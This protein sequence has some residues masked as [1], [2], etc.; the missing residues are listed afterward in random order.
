MFV[1]TLIIFSTIGFEYLSVDPVAHRVGM[2]YAMMNDGYSV[3]Y[4]P[5]G[6]AFSTTTYYSASYLNYMGGTNFG[7]L[8]YERS[9]LGI[10][11]RYFNSGTM[12]KT[13]EW[14]NEYGGFGAQFIDLNVGKGFIYKTVG[15]GFSAKIV[16]ENID[17]LYALG[18]GIDIG[19][20]HT[21]AQPGIQIGLALKNAGFGIKSFIN[22]NETLPYEIDLGVIKQFGPGW[23]GL[24]LAKPALT[25]FGLRV[26]GGY[27]VTPLVTLKASYNT[28]LSSIQTGGGGL[29][30][31]AGLT[32]GLSVK[33]GKFCIDYSYSP[34]FDF[35]GGHRFSISMGG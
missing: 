12:K 4:N 5:A 13:D 17:T 18:A 30:F 23:F 20:L 35:G 10:A 33:A 21:L 11:I 25:G 9:Q 31:L 26:G 27:T 2:G 32:G 14:G 34:Y 19:V 28:L 22:E 3:H 16:Y 1:A 29:D 24:D 7:L 15:L 8:A 6:L